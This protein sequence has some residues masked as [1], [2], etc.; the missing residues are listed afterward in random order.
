[1]VS[2]ILVGIPEKRNIMVQAL[3]VPRFRESWWEFFEVEKCLPKL[4]GGN[5]ARWVIE[6]AEGHN[7][8]LIHTRNYLPLK[9]AFHADW[10][11]VQETERTVALV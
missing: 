10:L 6:Q 11:L 2:L 7:I 8:R 9:T 3:A 4:A 1:M 5:V